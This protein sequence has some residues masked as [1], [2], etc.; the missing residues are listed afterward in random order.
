[1]R[2]ERA[3]LSLAPNS[4]VITGM[5]AHGTS[6]YAS[7]DPTLPK[8]RHHPLR[9]ALAENPPGLASAESGLATP[10]RCA[11]SRFGEL[12]DRQVSVPT[13]GDEGRLPNSL[14]SLF[15]PDVPLNLETL[16][17]IASYAVAMA[18][19]GLLHS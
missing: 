15:F 4:F 9:Y 2:R 12:R 13:V 8:T 19:V 16:R 11:A 6:N 5:A 18:L 10:A 17:I 3:S 1:V 7:Q 14:R